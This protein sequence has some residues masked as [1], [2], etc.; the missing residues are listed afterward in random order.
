MQYSFSKFFSLQG[1]VLKA[2]P[3][4]LYCSHD[5][6]T[7]QI[8][9]LA[10]VWPSFGKRRRAA[11]K[12]SGHHWEHYATFRDRIVPQQATGMGLGEWAIV[13]QPTVELSECEPV[14]CA[15]LG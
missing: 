13:T 7:G 2:G 11:A 1:K 6:H 5:F 15:G 12:G 4:Q 10:T 14:H 3:D 9:E 8:T